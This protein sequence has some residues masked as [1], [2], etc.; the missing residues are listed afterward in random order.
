MKKIFTIAWKD[1][2]IRFSSAS[3]LLFFI[4]LPVI[5]TVLL[6]GGTS[7]GG[8]ESRIR[9]LVVDEAQTSIS[10]QIIQELDASTA[11]YPV[12]TDREEAQKLFDARNASTIF[13]IPAGVDAA[14]LQNGAAEVELMKQPNNI[15]A[16]VVERA[17]A[18]EERAADRYDRAWSSWRTAP[19]RVPPALLVAS[20][21]LETGEL[22]DEEK[23]LR[24]SIQLHKKLRQTVHR[25]SDLRKRNRPP[26]SGGDFLETFW[27]DLIKAEILT[28]AVKHLVAHL[29]RR[30]LLPKTAT[31]N[32][33]SGDADV[34]PIEQ[35][36]ELF[37]LLG[38]VP[39]Q[40]GVELTESYLMVPNKTISGIRFATEL[41]FRSC[42]VCQRPVCPNRVAAFDEPLWA[43][44]QHD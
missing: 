1:A 5:F 18:S 20:T 32:P 37:A 17:A 31:M 42:Q 25:I 39:K 16:T 15:N 43:S 11:V 12:I 21:A 4:I 3:E 19:W 29:S 44:I 7:G 10:G 33:G 40:V 9:L 38:D 23:A 27:W 6:G 14:S 2:I 8:G 30:F 22:R 36:R 13:I 41:D 28:A 26:L 34:W 35:Q 24:E